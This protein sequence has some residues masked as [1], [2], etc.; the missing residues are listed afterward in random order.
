MFFCKATSVPL[1]SVLKLML[2]YAMASDLGLLFL[3]GQRMEMDVDL[4]VVKAE[5]ENETPT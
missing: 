1:F 3:N 4:A 5:P 2:T